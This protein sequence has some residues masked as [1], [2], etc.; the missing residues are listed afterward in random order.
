[1]HVFRCET[2]YLCTTDR[3]L[4]P[5]GTFLLYPLTRLEELQLHKHSISEEVRGAVLDV[6]LTCQP[7][8]SDY[9]VMSTNFAQMK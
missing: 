5:L 7:R 9:N 4:A 6:G 8:P 1:M 3:A 2:Q